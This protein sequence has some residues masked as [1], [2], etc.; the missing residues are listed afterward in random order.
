MNHPLL[1]TLGNP[2]KP[3]SSGTVHNAEDLAQTRD[4]HFI[5]VDLE[6]LILGVLHPLWLLHFLCLLFHRF[7]ER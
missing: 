2:I 4:M 7:P 1:C 6:N 5:L 3:L